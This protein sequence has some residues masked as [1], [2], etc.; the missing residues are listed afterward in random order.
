MGGRLRLVSMAIIYDAELIPSKSE[1]LTQWLPRQ[2]WFSG[3][4]A[5]LAVLGAFRFDDPAGEVGV[6]THLLR[7]GERTYQVPLTYRSTPLAGADEFLITT[8]EHSVLGT[9][10]IYDAT[11]DP[12]YV[13][14]LAAALLAGKPQAKELLVVGDS[15]KMLPETARIKSGGTS[16][17]VLP[18]VSAG[19]PTTIDAVTSIPVGSLELA[20]LRELD[21]NGSFDRA[22]SLTATWEGQPDPVVLAVASSKMA[23]Q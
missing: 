21:T 14:E 12:V 2:P 11:A 6:E 8:M 20:V 15:R 13:G 10:W 4:A 22:A 7:V 3:D 9:R 16:D 23:P 18:A 1:L 5:G 19:V 17:A